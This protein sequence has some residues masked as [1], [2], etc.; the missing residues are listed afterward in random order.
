[1]P[2]RSRS[3]EPDQPTR[4][5]VEHEL[6]RVFGDGVRPLRFEEAL[7]EAI[8]AGWVRQQ[9]TRLLSEATIR[10][11]AA[12][13]RR[14]HAHAGAW[15]WE[16]RAEDLEEWIEDLAVGPPGLHVS[17]L[18]SYQIA[19]RLFCE[20]LIDRRYPWVAICRERLGAA[21]QQIVDER[22]LIVHV[23]EFEADPRRRPLSREE[24]NRT[25][26][27]LTCSCSAIP[28]AIT[29]VDPLR[30]E[31]RAGVLEA[32]VDDP[33][34]RARGE[35]ARQR[36]DTV[37][38]A[39]E[40]RFLGA[41]LQ[42][43]FDHCDAQVA[44]RHALKR[45]GSLAAL[46]DAAMFKTIYAWGLRRREAAKLDVVD[47][48]RNPHKP[49]FGGFGALSVRYG[50]AMASGPPRRRSVLTVFDWAVEVI[51]QYLREIRPL[52]GRDE[53]PALWLTERGGREGDL[54]L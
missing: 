14:L 30:Y 10:P 41:R 48:S 12:L 15:P 34:A 3:S 45:K 49:A 20:Y 54:H 43:F 42:A 44:G 47:F 53:H 35:A 18:R 36:D 23:A 51:E 4:F 52:Y 16:W 21:P 39:R 27:E 29:E 2:P 37:A 5:N 25:I 9:R 22:N 17:T 46:R 7:F 50:K 40:H 33:A 28:L 1:M 32:A 26:A 11:R 38:V 8:L 6:A 13:V 24:A 19:I 31:M